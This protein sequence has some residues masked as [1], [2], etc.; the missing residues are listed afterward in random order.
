MDKSFDNSSD[1]YSKNSYCQILMVVLTLIGGAMF[2]TLWAT[3]PLVIIPSDGSDLVV[4][5]SSVLQFLSISN[6]PKGIRFVVT[7]SANV[8][9]SMLDSKICQHR[10]VKAL[11]IEIEDAFDRDFLGD[12]LVRADLYGLEV[13][14]FYKELQIMYVI[15]YIEG[16][17]YTS[18]V[19]YEVVK[20][21]AGYCD[22]YM[23]LIERLS[24]DYE[25]LYSD[26]Y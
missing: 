12:K 13:N 19:V 23:R 3:K 8:P 9:P 20:A 5:R 10:I 4:P 24:D 1:K 21:L 26:E 14:T 7:V 25:E 15:K 2:L 16:Q 6:D 22:E 17:G 18:E 11:Q